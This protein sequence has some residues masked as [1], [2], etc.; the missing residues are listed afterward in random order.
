MIESAVFAVLIGFYFF[1]N[2]SEIPLKEA[3][4]AIML[5]SV[6]LI[7]YL[8]VAPFPGYTSKYLGQ[9]YG[10]LPLLSVGAIL[11]PHFNTESPEVVTRHLGWGGLIVALIILS[12]FK[13]FVW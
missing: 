12:Y 9:L 4:F 8:F 11:F 10:L 5:Y 13:L 1:S 6:Y 2:G 7:V 3:V